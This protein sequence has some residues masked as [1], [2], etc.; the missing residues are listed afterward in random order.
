[1]GSLLGGQPIGYCRAPA[2]N[3]RAANRAFVIS[4]FRREPRRH[5]A[6]ADEI[7][8]QAENLHRAI[9]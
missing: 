1:L 3:C 7:A 2:G 9:L 5:L 8:K 6:G 4:G